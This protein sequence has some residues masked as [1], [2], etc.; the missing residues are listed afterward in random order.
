MKTA[1]TVIL[2]PVLAI[3]ISPTILGGW[4]PHS[5]DLHWKA[6][7]GAKTYNVYRAE[8]SGGPYKKI[9]CCIKQPHY[10]DLDVESGK[11]YY[12]VTT[13]VNERGESKYSVEI[14]AVVPK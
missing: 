7:A 1:M 11:T 3:V 4:K 9:T 10:R 14:E 2:G 12:Y 13:A 5:V 8:H 6:S